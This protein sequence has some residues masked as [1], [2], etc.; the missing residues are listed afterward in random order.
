MSIKRLIDP[1]VTKEKLDCFV[2]NIQCKKNMSCAETCFVGGIVQKFQDFAQNDETVN[3]VSYWSVADNDGFNTLEDQ[4]CGTY[5]EREQ[6][7]SK[8]IKKYNFYSDCLI[9][10]PAP[11]TFKLNFK[12]GAGFGGPKDVQLLKFEF[13][14]SDDG[15]GTTRYYKDTSGNPDSGGITLNASGISGSAGGVMDIHATVWTIENN[16]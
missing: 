15:A 6:T 16:E 5:F 1:D 14:V 11:S 3:Q 10:N 2:E 8:T 12:P 13:K 9:D 4:T 7:F